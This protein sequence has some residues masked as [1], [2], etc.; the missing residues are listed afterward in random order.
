MGVGRMAAGPGDAAAT[1]GLRGAVV[2]SSVP[3]P[4]GAVCAEALWDSRKG[5]LLPWLTR[6]DVRAQS[7]LEAGSSQHL[8]Q[9]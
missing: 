5:E 1:R 8:D 3:A 2:Q 9:R 7:V 6:K 4:R